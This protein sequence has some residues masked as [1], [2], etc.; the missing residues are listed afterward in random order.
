MIPHSIWFVG[1]DKGM[2][3]C[4]ECR[5]D[6]G[7]GTNGENA[8]G[9]ANTTGFSNT[10]G[11][12]NA[13]VGPDRG[14]AQG[15]LVRGRGQGRGRGGGSGNA[16]YNDQAGKKGVGEA[17]GGGDRRDEGRAI[18]A[19]VGATLADSNHRSSAADPSGI[20][21]DDHNVGSGRDRHSILGV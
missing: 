19:D 20:A 6:G 3:L 5:Y 10:T 13:I 4:Q 21:E 14:G 1:Q 15:G 17:D 18:Q 7:D 9:A 16:G 12:A 11:V 2:L 8:S